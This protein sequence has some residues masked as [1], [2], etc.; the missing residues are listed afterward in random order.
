MSDYFKVIIDYV[1]ITWPYFFLAASFEAALTIFAPVQGLV[2]PEVDFLKELN[3]LNRRI[4]RVS[5]LVG[6]GGTIIGIAG[7]LGPL[8]DAASGDRAGQ[9]LMKMFLQLQNAFFST[10]AGIVVVLW[11]EGNDFLFGLLNKRG[12]YHVSDASRTNRRWMDL[13]FVRR[14]WRG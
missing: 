3:A 10:L 2:P 7:A 6:F 12:S 5:L 11:G 4:A 9:A 8:A 1:G 14:K 13:P